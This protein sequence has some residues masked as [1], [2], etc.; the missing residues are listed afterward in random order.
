MLHPE[1][2]FI[3]GPVPLTKTQRR[4]VDFILAHAEQAAFMT[5]ADL[6]KALGVSD[7]TVV[8]VAQTLGFEGFSGIKTHLKG[9]VLGQ[10]DTVS[11][12]A[13]TMGNINTVEDVIAA[14][15]RNDLENLR[16][17]TETTPFNTVAK[18]AR[19]LDQAPEI[20]IVGLRSAHSLAHF[21]ASALRFLGRRVNMLAPG[22]GYLWAD[23]SELN[24]DS[25]L[26]VF[27]FPRYTKLTV[28]VAQE[29]YAAGATV[30]SFTDS[31]LSP[32]A[33]CSHHLIPASFQ[34]ESFM[35]SYVAALSLLNGLVTAMAYLDSDYS[36]QQLGELERVWREKGIYFP[37]ELT[38]PKKTNKKRAKKGAG[39]SAKEKKS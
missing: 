2:L 26:V 31:A 35:E 17:T 39:R 8:R 21:L 36:L 5:A 11:R 16:I 12:M 28:E 27:S 13:T 15:M 33:L 10:R 7:A 32:L 24:Q 23:V 14:V 18:V 38:P 22:I 30:I 19:I 25:V 9:K 1:D 3:N 29:A 20:H 4:V 6:G 34:M 37:E